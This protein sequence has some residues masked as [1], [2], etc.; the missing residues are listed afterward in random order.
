[1]LL[2]G[3]VENTSLWLLNISNVVSPCIAEDNPFRSDFL[4]CEIP[5]ASASWGLSY[6]DSFPFFIPRT[7]SLLF[8]CRPLVPLFTLE[9]WAH[10]ETSKVIWSMKCLGKMYTVDL[11]RGRAV[12][13]ISS[14]LRAHVSTPSQYCFP[15][16]GKENLHQSTLEI[17]WTVFETIN[18]NQ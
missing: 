8:F 7:L 18:E 12:L 14:P 4:C 3:K 5:R 17:L 13:L 15:P 9:Y 16:P 2:S 1:M 10:L 11:V 6:M